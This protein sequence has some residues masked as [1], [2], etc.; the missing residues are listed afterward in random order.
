MVIYKMVSMEI[1]DVQF[2]ITYHPLIN[3][4]ANLK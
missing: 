1:D 4:I 2:K 3:L